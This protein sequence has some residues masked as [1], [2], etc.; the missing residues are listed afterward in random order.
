MM[1]SPSAHV[2]PALG[3]ASAPASSVRSSSN[4]TAPKA[5]SCVLCSHR[6]VKC[7]KS[8]PCSNCRKRGVDCLFRAAAPP[9]RRKKTS[10]EAALLSRLKRAEELLQSHGI[11]VDAKDDDSHMADSQSDD[12]DVTTSVEGRDVTSHNKKTTVRSTAASGR[13]IVS[14]GQSRYLDKSVARESIGMIALLL[15]YV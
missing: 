12:M 7:D 9:R 3:P 15:T 13:L 6:K 14:E 11:P 10:P 5:Y 4:G 1:L 8:Y 2:T